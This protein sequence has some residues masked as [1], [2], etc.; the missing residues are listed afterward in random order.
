M[1]PARTVAR[2]EWYH[3]LKE[4]DYTLWLACK[5]REREIAEEQRAL[6]TKERLTFSQKADI[7]DSMS[8]IKDDPGYYLSLIH[9]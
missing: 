8:G 3:A 7:I 2:N 6:P 1:N 9:I 5:S 4:R